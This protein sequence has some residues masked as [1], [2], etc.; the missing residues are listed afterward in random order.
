MHRRRSSPARL[1]DKNAIGNSSHAYAVCLYAR[2][3]CL[4][5]LA[6]CLYAFMRLIRLPKN[7]KACGISRRLLDFKIRFQ[8]LAEWVWRQ[9]NSRCF[10]RFIDHEAVAAAVN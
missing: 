10:L 9:F 6:L 1:Y 4:Y 7:K 8:K 5:A 3:A 2:A